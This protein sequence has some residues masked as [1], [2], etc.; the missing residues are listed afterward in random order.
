MNAEYQ[1]TKAFFNYPC[2]HRQWRHDGN[3]HLLHGYSRSFSF[4]FG[5]EQRDKSGFVVDFGELKW[6]RNHLDHMFDHTLLICM[7][8]PLLG[9]FKELEQ[10]GAC[11]LR[12]L[13]YGVGM[14]D[15]AQY[16]CEWTDA[17]LRLRTKGRAWV[18]SVEARE[19]EKN[20][21]IYLN[22]TPG[23]LGWGP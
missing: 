23:F 17:E 12:T 4:L 21:A 5:A 11:S 13:P 20:S 7:D 15:T 6:L 22:P 10:A 3:C 8:D 19:N 1:S 18:I 2:A 9:K 16:L 14:E